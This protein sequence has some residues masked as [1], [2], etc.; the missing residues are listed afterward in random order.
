MGDK[1]KMEVMITREDGTK[2]Q[3]DKGVVIRTTEDK[4]MIDFI[5]L[6]DVDTC[7]CT[8]GLMDAIMSFGLNDMV[9][10]MIDSYYVDSKDFT[11]E[12]KVYGI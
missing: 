9:H 4:V 8:L 2:E 1:P 3:L 11:V 6:N 12:K 7:K 10:E 5:N